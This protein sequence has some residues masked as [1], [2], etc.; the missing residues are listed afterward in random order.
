[1]FFYINTMTSSFNQDMALKE[2]MQ[3]QQF[4][5][6]DMLD[7]LEEAIRETNPKDWTPEEVYPDLESEVRYLR[8]K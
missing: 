6:S 1:M 8:G 5:D 7:D 4:I 3:D 2:A